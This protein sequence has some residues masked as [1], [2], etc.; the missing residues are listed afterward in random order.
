MAVFITNEVN[1]Q[2]LDWTILRDGGIALYLRT[3]ILVDDVNWLKLNGYR[4]VS[5][6]T[7]DW[8]SEDQLHDSLKAELS[9]PAY[10][11]NNLNALDECMSDDLVVPDTG[12]LVLVLNHYDHF[13]K[14]DLRCGLNETSTAEIVLDIFARAVRYHMLLGR[15]LLILVQSDDPRIK[16][17]RLGGMPASWNSREWLNKNRGL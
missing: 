7:A 1:D 2:R 6:E 10:Y 4:I 3:E 15:R 5:F 8:L 16:F 12:G 9:F 11:G 17:G 14:A 13:I